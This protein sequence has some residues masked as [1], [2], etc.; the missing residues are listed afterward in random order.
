MRHGGSFQES[1]ECIDSV[2]ALLVDLGFDPDDI[3]DY[4]RAALEAFRAALPD[5]KVH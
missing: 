4:R 5:R 3:R 2:I 1:R